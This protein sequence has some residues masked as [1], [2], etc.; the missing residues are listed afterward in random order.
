MKRALVG[1]VVVAASLLFAGPA[2]A[3]A[4]QTT[5]FRFHGAFADALWFTSSDTNFVETFLNVSQAKQGQ[6]L[7]VDQFTENFDSSGNITGF[8]DTF[9]D[10][11]S[12]FS[13]TI[14]SLKLTSASASGSGLPATT[15]SYDADFNLI[16]CSVT[17]INVDATWTG[18][19][20]ISRGT[21]NDH[22][23][24]DGFKIRDHFNG[25]DRVASASGAIGGLTLTTND[26]VFADLGKTNS[27]STVLCIGSC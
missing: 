3:A 18:A 7:S 27:G 19:G 6:E 20:P 12:G 9:A 10:V 11:T 22:F 15:C 13:F 8:T 16:G 25:T 26:L 14:D 2:S 23:T 21:F 4:G 17:T 1:L 5:Q 24:T